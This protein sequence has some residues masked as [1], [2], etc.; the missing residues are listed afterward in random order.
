[1]EA[2]EKSLAVKE[3]DIRQLSLQ[4]EL[5]TNEN[6]VKEEELHLRITELQVNT[7]THA[8]TIR[9]K[10]GCWTHECHAAIGK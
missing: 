3:E 2:L 9:T 8:H 10:Q 7:H 1:M 6:R 4:L 5:K